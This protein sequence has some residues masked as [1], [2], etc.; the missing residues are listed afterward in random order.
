MSATKSEQDQQSK[1]QD[2][3][4]RQ[5]VRTSGDTNKVRTI[6]PTIRTARSGARIRMK[7]SAAKARAS[8][9]IR[10]RRNPKS[11]CSSPLP[12]TVMDGRGFQN[13]NTRPTWDY[14]SYGIIAL[15]GSISIACYKPRPGCEEALLELVATTCRRYA[16]WVWSLNALPS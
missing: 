15:M 6:L 13:R 14:D 7:N 4:K 1:Q 9:R 8:G 2:P 3:Q 12:C 16:P 5:E 10:S 11:V